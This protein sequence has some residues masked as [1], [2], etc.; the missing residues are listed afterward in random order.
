M[1]T[2]DESRFCRAL[3]YLHS[4]YDCDID[5][6]CLAAEAVLSPWHWRRH[7]PVWRSASRRWRRGCLCRCRRAGTPSALAG[8]LSLKASAAAWALPAM[9]VRRRARMLW[10]MV[11]PDVCKKPDGRGVVRA[12]WW[13][14]SRRSRAVL[15]CSGRGCPGSSSRFLPNRFCHPRF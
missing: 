7:R 8:M 13:R 9:A 12:V 3:R 11:F 10:F 2:H 1:R 15:R 5:L 4:H 6:N 14:F